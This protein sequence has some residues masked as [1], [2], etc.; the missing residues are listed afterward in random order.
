MVVLSKDSKIMFKN[1]DAF[2]HNIYVTLDDNKVFD[3]GLASP[4]AKKVEKIVWSD[5]YVAKVSCK[6]HPE[7][8]SWIA[9]V[10]SKYYSII[11][12]DKEK[13]KKFVIS[14][15]P[16]NLSTL[17]IWFPKYEKIEL[18]LKKGQSKVLEIKN[19]DTKKII[20]EVK[21]SIN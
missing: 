5:G 20:G 15:I 19:K 13:K 17:S 7:M 21:L 2:E 6:I 10:N 12:F 18:E 4:G 9:S 11:E 16:E 3:I 14:D 1:S 8:I